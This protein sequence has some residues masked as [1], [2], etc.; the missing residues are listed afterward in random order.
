MD[1]PK[2]IHKLN[3][4]RL[5]FGERWVLLLIGDFLMAVAALLFG[6]YFWAV[7]Q[8]IPDFVEFLKVRP[9][10]WV[11]LLPF[12]WPLL[13]LELYDTHR[14]ANR[15]NTIRGVLTAALLGIVLYAVI[16]FTS[17]PKSLPRRGVA[18]FVIF[19]SILTLLWRLFYIRVFTAPRF[20]HNAVLVGAGSTGQALL[21]VFNQ[22]S[23]PPFNLVGL[24][25]DDASKIGHEI[26]GF[27][28]I[29][30]SECLMDLITDHAVT[31]VLVAI[32]G[33]MEDHMFHALLDAQEQG[34]M[35]TRMPVAYEELLGRVPVHHLEADWIL[36]SFVNETRVG[37]F[38]DL[39]KRLLDI[40]GGLVGVV[41][42]VA[43]SPLI[44]LAVYLDIGKPIVFSQYR[45]GKG[46][47][48]YRII[49]FRTMVTRENQENDLQLAKEDDER[50]T[51]LGRLMRKTRLDEWPQFINV[52][53]GEMSLVGPRPEQFNLMTQYQQ[54]IPFYRGR[55]LVKP[56][57]TGW[58]QVN[59][60]Y[61][62]TMEGMTRK[63]E[64]DLYYIKHRN[65]WL[66]LVILLRT[67]GTVIGFRGQ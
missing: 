29:G 9:Q 62:T 48:P 19:A 47:Q 46:G 40:L 31:D 27:N 59:F 42:L 57:I 30:G 4:W 24:V 45:A 49:K 60:G 15:R 39:L 41:I 38:Y 8:E 16:Y 3:R 23:P 44:S 18:G 61:P 12:A 28:V 7:G 66:D 32:S 22:F 53:K 10:D 56:G 17:E 13:L 6:L 64:Y 2:P 1:H 36:R 43:I 65:I 63:L 14:A 25:D 52:L 58:A 54:Q 33:K 55:L 21:Q 20:M 37:G 26:E 67:I 35:I 51:K 34:V 5:R 11:F 50:T